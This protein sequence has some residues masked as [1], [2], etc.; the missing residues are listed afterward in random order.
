MSINRLVPRGTQT[1]GVYIE[2][3][4]PILSVVAGTTDGVPSDTGGH[5]V[6]S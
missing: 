6:G 4:G 1:D 5:L 2:K 3:D